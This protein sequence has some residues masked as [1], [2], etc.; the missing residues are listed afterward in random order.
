MM[1][2]EIA[3]FEHGADCSVIKMISHAESK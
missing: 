1:I 3:F 2:R